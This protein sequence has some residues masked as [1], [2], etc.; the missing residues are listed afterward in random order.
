MGVGNRMKGP[1]HSMQ[2]L[3]LSVL[4][5]VKAFRKIEKGVAAFGC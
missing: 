3:N 1:Q 5:L 2:A 4:Y